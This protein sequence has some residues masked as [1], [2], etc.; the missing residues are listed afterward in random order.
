MTVF[1]KTL[2]LKACQATKGKNLTSSFSFITKGDNKNIW[3]LSCL[4]HLKIPFVY[5]GNRK[6]K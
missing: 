1:R 6:F 4:I 3:L 5:Y 2:L